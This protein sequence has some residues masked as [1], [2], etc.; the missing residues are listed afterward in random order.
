M[1]NTICT[2]AGHSAKLGYKGDSGPAT[3]ADLYIPMASLI[4][5]DG[6][7]WFIDFNNYVVRQIDAQGDIH[8]LIGN[9]QLGDS[10]ASDGLTSIPA[11]QAFNNHTPTMTFANGYLY[12]AAWHESRIKRVRLSDMMMENVAG[13]ATRGLYDGDGAD[14]LKAALSLPS[15]ITFDPQGNLVLMD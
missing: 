9:G 15:S 1:P 5:A 6:T 10:P 7:V 3:S 4:A 8:T 11:L 2:I 13:R 12:L 14:P